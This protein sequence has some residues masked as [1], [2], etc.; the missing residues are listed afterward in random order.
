MKPLLLLVSL[1]GLLLGGCQAPAAN[2]A[3]A[4]RTPEF[5]PTAMKAN[6]P[7]PFSEAVRVGDMLYLA[8]QLGTLPGTTQVAPGGIDAEARQVMENIRAVLERHGTSLDHAV[9][10]T[11]FLADMKEW[12]AFNAAYRGFFKKDFPARSA[13]GTTGLAF[14]ARV[15]VECVAWIPPA[16][17]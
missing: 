2:T 1:G 3:A 8:G 9:K 5:F 7:L 4:D 11:V 15:E 12:P 13:F 14:G 17:K 6:P 16:A 10:C